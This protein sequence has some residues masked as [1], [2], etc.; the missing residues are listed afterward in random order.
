M[1]TPCALL[2]LSLTA[3]MDSTLNPLGGVAGPRLDFTA[4]A[5]KYY[6]GGRAAYAHVEQGRIVV[7]GRGVTP[8]RCH[9]LTGALSEAG[10]ELKLR[11]DAEPAQG[12]DV[13]CGDA[14]GVAEY[15][16]VIWNL[17]P[18]EYRLHVFD[19][20]HPDVGILAQSIRV[21]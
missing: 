11:L 8:T 19:A 6:G 21:P 10:S 16:A 5:P 17:G 2:L 9:R 3:C 15:R 4:S 13:A 12:P 14:L 7:Q 18:G 1:R 20:R